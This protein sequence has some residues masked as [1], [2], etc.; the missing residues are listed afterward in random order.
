MKQGILQVVKKV[1]GREEII[2]NN[3]KYCLK[4][5][6][7]HAG[8]R[9]SLHHHKKKQE[10]WYVLSGIVRV[11]L[12]GELFDMNPFDCLEIV[13]GDRHWFGALKQARILEV[14]TQHFD[15]DSYREDLS[16]KMTSE[17]LKS[18]D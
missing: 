5:L 7:V 8:F 15:S 10:H 17:E 9:S 3:E 16:R 13:P 11:W 18:L 14:S 6:H 2:V 4:I 1:W 12:N